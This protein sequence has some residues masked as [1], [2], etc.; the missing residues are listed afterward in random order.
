VR[1][2]LS[3]ALLCRYS[4]PTIHFVDE[5]YDT[6]PIVAQRAVPCYP[7]DTPE[8]LAA[9][10]LRQEHELYPQTVAALC[11]DRIAWRHDGVPYVWQRL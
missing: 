3:C 1:W 5:D 2:T 8:A 9:R 4:G 11:D 6:G 10:V 7:D